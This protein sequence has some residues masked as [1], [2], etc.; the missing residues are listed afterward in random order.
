MVSPNGVGMGH[1]ARLL[2]VA[3]RL[4]G[5]V[6]P[7][8][9]TMS[10]AVD[11]VGRYGFHGEYLPYHSYYGG[12][13]DYWNRGLLAR[14]QAM[15]G[16][17]DLRRVCPERRFLWLRR[18]L[19]RP[20]AGKVAIDRHTIFDMIVE[21]GEFAAEA[22]RGLT[23]TRGG[24][25]VHVP[26]VTLLDPDEILDRQAARSE[27]SIA[28][29]A[30]AVAV[31]LGSQN[32]FDYGPIRRTIA[33]RLGQRPDLVMVEAEW[34]I[35]E[36]NGTALLPGARALSGFPLARLFKAFDFAIST[37]GYN[38]FHE[39]LSIGV[40]A[41]FVPNENP[42]MDEQEARAGWAERHGLGLAIRSHET[43]RLAWAL[44][45]MQAPG[46][47]GRMRRNAAALPAADGGREIARLIAEQVVARDVVAQAA[48][49]P[50]LAPRSAPLLA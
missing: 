33:A 17:Y 18:G 40:P 5:T 6:E 32:N 43:D 27:L 42:S 35:S 2:A 9:L 8:F 50:Y 25:V 48:P 31:L 49:L 41:I 10:Q 24:E 28:P 29:D 39:L 19:W 12:D 3:R 22:D 37:A 4:P 15:I 14:L 13:P 23:R 20:E 7:I 45:A 21:P 38:S 1:L 36:A 44:D 46:V 47:A 30:T 11:V 26:P 16:F 34:L